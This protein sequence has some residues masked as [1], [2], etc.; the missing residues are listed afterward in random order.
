MA[1]KSNVGFGPESTTSDVLKG[2][3]LDGQHMLVT[4]GTGGLGLETARALA[5]VGAAITITGRDRKKLDAAVATLAAEVP[6]SSV[7]SVMCD[8]ASLAS[9]RE[10]AAQI[11]DGA[12]ID[13]QINNAGVMMCPHLRTADGFEM[14]T[15]TNHLG[16]FA[17]SA[18]IEPV[19]AEAARVVS[20]SSSAH[21]RE[22]VDLTDLNWETREYDKF[23]SYSQSKTANVWFAT[24]LQRRRPNLSVFALHPGA[25]ATDLARH[26][27]RDDLVAMQKKA[28]SKGGGPMPM[29]TIPQG[30][31]TSVW[32]AT[33][34]EL[35]NEAKG[36]F[37]ADCRVAPAI[38]ESYDPRVG[39]AP[40]AYDEQGAAELWRQ[41][42]ELT[43][44]DYN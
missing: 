1:S 12:P 17:L 15:G 13:V 6:G 29:K 41:S 39:Y 22:T 27:T 10:G 33:A 23:A 38:A 32:A 43:G 31:A 42:V 44:V 5:S 3:H 21:L 11:L 16:H 20:V 14:Q 8:L 34:P 9:V 2:V 18:Q 30:A 24:E 37:L 25:I 36:K 28:S 35:P 4:G 40:W 26:L 19:L 7:R